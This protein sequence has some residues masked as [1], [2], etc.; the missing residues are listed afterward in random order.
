MVDKESVRSILREVLEVA[1]RA[2]RQY[3]SGLVRFPEAS[4]GEAV[5]R[6]LEQRGIDRTALSWVRDLPGQVA[7]WMDALNTMEER[8]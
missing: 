4:V 6:G 2:N 8:E 7:V 1:Y 3:F 5:I